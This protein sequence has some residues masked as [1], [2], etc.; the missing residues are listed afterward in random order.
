MECN[1]QSKKKKTC[2]QASGQVSKRTNSISIPLKPN[3]RQA[4][5]PD[6]RIKQRRP[7]SVWI[8]NST[9]THIN[10]YLEFTKARQLHQLLYTTYYSKMKR[11]ISSH[12]CFAVKHDGDTSDTDDK[13]F[14]S[15]VVP[16]VV[17]KRASEKLDV[18]L[19]ILD[20]SFS[21]VRPIGEVPSTSRRPP[22][23]ATCGISDDVPDFENVITLTP[24]EEDLRMERIQNFSKEVR[25]EYQLRQETQNWFCGLQFCIDE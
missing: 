14:N 6:N 17:K 11:T 13:S 15:K 19:V 20:G 21:E 2:K 16:A 18:S 12:A 4:E 25:E 1:S 10:R 5:L 3:V 9:V 7:Q 23:T 8:T 24:R 22:G